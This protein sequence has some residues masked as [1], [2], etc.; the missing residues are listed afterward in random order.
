MVRIMKR[1][2][3]IILLIPVLHLLSVIAV[4]AQQSQKLPFGP[5]ET[6]S[7]EG[8][9]NKIIR[10]IAV[11]D[12]TFTIEAT[13][14][15]NQ[16]SLKTDAKSK[17][18]LLKLFRF[19]FLQQYESIVEQNSFRILKTVKT[20]VQKDRVRNSEAIFDYTENKVTFTEVNPKEPMR[21]PRTIASEIRPDTQDLVSGVY[22]LRTLPLAVGKVFMINVSDSGLI[23]QVPVRVTGRETQKTVLGKVQCF[24]IEPEIF[25]NNRL[26]EQKG[27]MII[28]ITD[29]ERRIPIRSK[30]KTELGKL[31]VKLKSASFGAN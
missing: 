16:I 17:G 5:G 27:S 22:F 15:E 12:L 26:I 10:G 11:A 20:D 25:G 23:Y 21:A 1:A 28:W 30:I 24:K 3:R 6:L 7:Y 9:I 19:S 18:T 29:D 8:K 14:K 2:F 4:N 13:G 31:D